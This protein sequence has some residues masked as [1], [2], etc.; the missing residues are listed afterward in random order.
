MGGGTGKGGLKENYEIQSEKGGLN[1]PEIAEYNI[2]IL[3][4]LYK[5][6]ICSCLEVI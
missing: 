6:I 5:H 2:C 1:R 4:I 3:C